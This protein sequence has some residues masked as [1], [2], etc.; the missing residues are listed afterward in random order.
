M[1]TAVKDIV[2]K[3][4]KF[5]VDG[6]RRNI[7]EMD[8][9]GYG[10]SDNTGEAKNSLKFEI[11][12]KGIRIFSDMPGRPFNYLFTLEDGRKPGKMPPVQN[13]QQW[14]EQRGINPP[15]ISQKSLA[16]LI[17]RRIGREGS[18]IYRKGGKSGVISEAINDR[19]IRE[20]L[21]VPLR[22]VLQRE[23]RATLTA[24]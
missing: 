5:V 1:N 23:F 20:Q 22:K 3:F 18:T 8:A 11:T 7:E 10:P 4:C 19:I 24:A 9:T 13:I 2:E 17:A 6:I 12:D 16:F 14:L 15:D 21:V